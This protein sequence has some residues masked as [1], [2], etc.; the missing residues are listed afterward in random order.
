[1]LYYAM[2]MALHSLSALSYLQNFHKN[3]P[4]YKQSHLFVFQQHNA[5]TPPISG[6]ELLL[7]VTTGVPQAIDSNNG[8]PKPSNDET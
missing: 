4:Y 6:K 5:H 3:T 7:H 8:K 1:M 2:R